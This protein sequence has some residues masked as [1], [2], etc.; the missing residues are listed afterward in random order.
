MSVLISSHLMGYSL[1]VCLIALWL[2]MSEERD[3]E[4]EVEKHSL[5]SVSTRRKIVRKE[6]QMNKIFL[7]VEFPLF[8]SIQR[9][10]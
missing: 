4:N 1:N 2:T 7:D 6:K 8:T 9:S 5:R 10:L 3:Q